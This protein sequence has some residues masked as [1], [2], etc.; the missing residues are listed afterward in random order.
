MKK[1]KIFLL[2]NLDISKKIFSMKRRRSEEKETIIGK[3]S[4]HKL[5]YQFEKH[6]CAHRTIGDT[7]PEWLNKLALLTFWE[8]P[9]QTA[10]AFGAITEDIYCLDTVAIV[11][12][13]NQSLCTEFY[14]NDEIKRSFIVTVGKYSYLL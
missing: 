12:A 13:V 14:V 10:I 6:L 11:F 1:D 2:E 7:I 5:Q 9:V 4:I 3:E 8:S